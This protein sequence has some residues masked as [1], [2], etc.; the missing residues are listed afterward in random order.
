MAVLLMLS[1]Q[2]KQLLANLDC[3]A[4]I[5]LAAPAPVWQSGNLISRGAGLNWTLSTGRQP[6]KNNQVD[7]QLRHSGTDIYIQVDC[8]DRVCI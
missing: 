4:L 8:S 2:N 6:L 3:D 5:A 1:Y 7:I